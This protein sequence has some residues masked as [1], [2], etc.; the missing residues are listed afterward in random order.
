MTLTE[1][2]DSFSIEEI[3]ITE[4]NSMLN[5]KSYDNIIKQK[6]LGILSVRSNNQ[7][8]DK[9]CVRCVRNYYTDSE[10]GTA[11]KMKSGMNT[12]NKSCFFVKKTLNVNYEGCID[13]HKDCIAKLNQGRIYRV[14]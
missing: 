3:P 5:K 11:I 2:L 9:K 13:C 4:M 1:Y 14:R 7:S 12:P 6:I 10:D 8:Y